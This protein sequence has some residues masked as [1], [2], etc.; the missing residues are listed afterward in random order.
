[1]QFALAAWTLSA[2]TFAG[3]YGQVSAEFRRQVQAI[4]GTREKEVS[5]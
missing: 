1:M 2:L 5:E 3:E 4:R